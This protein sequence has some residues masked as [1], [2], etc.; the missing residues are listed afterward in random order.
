MSDVITETLLEMHYHRA[1]VDFFAN[2]YGADFLRLLK[3][4]TQDEVWVGFDQGWVHTSLTTR[5]LF[6]EL[7]ESLQSQSQQVDHFYLGFFLQFKP[8]QK[9]VRRSK[10]M[11]NGYE[12]PYYRSELSLHVNKRSKLSQHE[13]LLR[14]NKLKAAQVSYACALLVDLDEIYQPVNLERLRCID[15]T[16]S[17]SGWAKDERH[18]ITFQ[19]EV[20]TDALWCSEPVTT[21]SLDFREWASPNR[22][23]GIG[24][25]TAEEV[26]NLLRDSVRAI[27]TVDGVPIS[28]SDN[29]EQHIQLEMFELDSVEV[30]TIVPSSLTL[31]EYRT[32]E[33]S[34]EYVK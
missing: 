7:R 8:V 19:N 1:I 33:T 27:S 25:L 17:P 10:L 12:L 4:S 21:E 9:M 16:T 26:I 31:L 29:P 32:V 34:P 22:E 24:K 6:K 28:S 15:L 18:F 11:P 23:R 2:V 3:P 20:D 5:E 30:A 14:L 13:T